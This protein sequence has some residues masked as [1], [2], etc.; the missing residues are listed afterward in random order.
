MADFNAL[1]DEAELPERTVNVCLRGKLRGDW[2]KLDEQYKEARQRDR[3]SLSDDGGRAI[4]DEMRDLEEQ[5]RAS[6]VAVRLRALPDD[7]EGTPGRVRFNKLIAAHPPRQGNRRDANLG[8]NLDTF[9]DALVP[10]SVVDVTAH[11]GD[12]F[13]P[14]AE[15]I[16]KLLGKIT[17]KQWNDLADAAFVLNGGSVDIPF[18][19]TASRTIRDSDETSRRQSDSA[20]ASGGGTAGS[21]KKSPNTRTTKKGG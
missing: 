4:T 21:R 13:V 6:T 14:D 8:V 12:V 10:L 3:Q 20:S 18:S 16:V 7:E 11:D 15:W 9:F 5:M 1:L 2:E 19:P 17:S